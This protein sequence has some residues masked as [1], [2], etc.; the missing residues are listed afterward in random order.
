[1]KDKKLK[2]IWSWIGSK[3]V[4]K[5]GVTNKQVIEKFGLESKPIWDKMKTNLRCD[6]GM[7]HEKGRWFRWHEN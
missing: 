2:E 1:M 6:N 4:Y 5:L 3:E 7:F